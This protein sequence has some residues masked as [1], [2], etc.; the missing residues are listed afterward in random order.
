MSRDQRLPP[1]EVISPDALALVRYGLRAPD[2][3]R[4]VNTVKA[5]DDVLKV[6]TPFGPSWRRYNGD[7]YGEHAD[8]SPYDG[9]T[10]GIGRAW[11]LLTGERAHYE[12]AAGRPGEAARLLAA[13]AAFAGDGGLIPE[14]VWDDADIPERHLYRGRATGSAM[15]LVWAHAEYLKLCRSL[16]EDRVFDR[17][18]QTARRYLEGR[19]GSDK[20]L[21]RFN[22]R[23]RAIATGETL[24]IELPTAAVVRW[25]ADDGAT[26]RDQPNARHDAGCSCG[27]PADRRPAPGRQGR[28]RR[29]LARGRSRGGSG[30]Q[31]QRGR[32]AGLREG[33]WALRAI[34][35]SCGSSDHRGSSR[36]GVR[37]KSA[38]SSCAEG[39]T[40]T[41]G[42]HRPPRPR[43][44]RALAA[45]PHSS[46]ISLRA[47]HC[48][49]SS[50]R[51]HLC[52]RGPPS[53][54]SS[55]SAFP[56]KNG[57]EFSTGPT[58]S[59]PLVHQAFRSR[60]NPA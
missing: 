55:G 41:G 33:R 39:V 40:W 44:D 48:V 45:P 24:R 15:P 27:R 23:R 20:A 13:M 31:R 43:T 50:V 37:S 53:P 22:H 58:C 42:G 19:V 46:P 32:E 16:D 6:E 47:H 12:L 60:D 2:D 59:W 38:H 49:P 25:T 18:P 9:R 21:W 35:S 4:I 7:G 28:V 1:E 51:V 8:G 14:Q 36:T 5:I 11:P 54:T 56:I 10:R 17:P 3:P 52:S 29:P 34:A 57:S 30:F 26:H